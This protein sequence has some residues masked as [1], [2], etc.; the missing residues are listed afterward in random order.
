SP[1]AP[2]S[3]VMCA[4][5]SSRNLL[6]M[7][8]VATCRDPQLCRSAAVIALRDLV[9]LGDQGS[10]QLERD[11]LPPLAGFVFVPRLT[12]RTTLARSVIGSELDQWKSFRDS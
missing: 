2:I 1:V 4:L 3:A 12:H 11:H 10:G 8:D 7:L 9:D 5:L 6:D